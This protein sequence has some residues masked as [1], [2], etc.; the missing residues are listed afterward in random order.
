MSSHVIRS[1]ILRFF[2]NKKS[3]EKM[4]LLV[5]TRGFNSGIDIDHEY[6]C[7]VVKL[8]ASY[9]DERLLTLDASTYGCI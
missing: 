9:V 2:S 8:L 1:Q 7:I 4:L 3:H 5:Y 6:L